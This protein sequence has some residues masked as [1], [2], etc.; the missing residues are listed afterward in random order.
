MDGAA[1][2]T[3]SVINQ[4]GGCGKTT[5][6]I[7]LAAAFA[8][9]GYKTLLVDMDPQSHCALGLAVPESGI[10]RSVADVLTGDVPGTGRATGTDGP[11]DGGL[12]WHVR[13][14]L[15][16]IPSTTQLAAVEHRLAAQAD[17]DL[18][19]ARGLARLR[20]DHDV[21]VIDCPPS[22]GLLT[23][24]ALRA[25]REVIIPVETAYFS[26]HGALKQAMTLQVLA[27]R[28]RHDVA[29]YVLPTMHD[30]QTALADQIIAELK[31]HFGPRVLDI[32]IRYSLQLKEAASLGQPVGEYDPQ[33][34]AADDYRRLAAYLLSLEPAAG[35]L[36][37]PEATAATEALMCERPAPSIDV[38]PLSADHG[39]HGSGD[40]VADLLQRTRAMAQRKL[41][42]RLAASS[43]RG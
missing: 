33:G 37:A 4:K 8:E 1:V 34:Q 41:A 38:M 30:G 11:S 2:R 28:A 19:L 23:F 35:R 14:R 10:E 43:E 6:S 9:A 20:P 26:L 31:R 24:N 39:A 22:I 13:D 3:F 15:D 5:T 42:A 16:L 27:D 18:R 17:R 12:V 25:S 32:T 7:N 36:K 40:R 21:C 29:F